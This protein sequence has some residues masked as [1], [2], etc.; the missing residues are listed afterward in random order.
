MQAPRNVIA[1]GISAAVIFGPAGPASAQSAA[2]ASQAAEAASLSEAALIN[3]AKP[4]SQKPRS[5]MAATPQSTIQHAAGHTIPPET[6]SAVMPEGDRPQLE[7]RFAQ[8]PLDEPPDADSEAEADSETDVEL[9]IEDDVESG[10]Q[11]SVE[12]FETERD[13]DSVSD[14]DTDSDTPAGIPPSAP[15][16]EDE[17]EAAEE[18]D[19]ESVT[20]FLEEGGGETESPTEVE[21]D[22]LSQPLE[23]NG[24]EDI[25]ADADELEEESVEAAPPEEDLE[26]ETP[27]IVQDVLEALRAPANPL[28][29][30]TDPETLEI[31]ENIPITLEQS[32][33]LAYRNS[34]DLQN[35]QLTFE[36]AQAALREAQAQRFPTLSAASDYTR[37]TTNTFIDGTPTTFIDGSISEPGNQTDTD[38]SVSG[39]VTLGYDIFTSGQRQAS[40]RA[41]REARRFQALQIEVVAEEIQL[42]VTQAYY[43]IQEADETVRINRDN[44]DEAL[45]SFRDAS[46]RERAGVGTRFDRLQA[47]VEVA[48]SRQD[49]R[50]SISDQITA[51]RQLVDL[52][53]LPPG[54]NITAADP[55][56]IAGRWQLSLENSL[57]LAYQNRAELE[58]QLV[59]REIDRQQRRVARSSTLPQLSLVAQY[60]INDLL[61]ATRSDAGG[62]SDAFSIAAQLDWLLFDGG[63]SRAASRQESLDIEIAETT[64]ADTREAI[65][66]EVESAFFDL[67]SNFENIE[68]AQ[69]AVRLAEESLR[70]ARLRFQA[71][72]GIQS[73]VIQAQ[74]DLTEAEGNLVTAVLGYNRALVSIQ[75]AVSNLPDNNLADIPP[76]NI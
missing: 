49:L 35:A 11:D 25:E 23:L 46:A 43:D 61:D 65:R 68:T 31:T 50:N 8:T 22:P 73:D 41:A 38:S 20:D 21:P 62:D 74:T 19:L 14:P 53:S 44:L 64:F 18:A 28:F 58:Q 32:L 57:A 71:G 48:N 9:E 60:Q 5:W 42:N 7:Q 24:E 30:P 52:L 12:G 72:V 45:I 47:Q 56:D 4:P 15:G 67:E 17:A 10:T 2:S 3:A 33:Q 6:N 54:I 34:R 39:S 27:E 55:V 29:F 37:S 51:Q 13:A 69:A 1:I 59:Q 66:F 26:E 36:Q 70:L 16:V 75:R 63:A 40:I 76:G